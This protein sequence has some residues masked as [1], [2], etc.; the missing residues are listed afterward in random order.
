M[1]G[2]PTSPEAAP[3]Q[4][5]E[6]PAVVAGIGGAA[7]AAAVPEA[8]TPA[9]A[10]EAPAMPEVKEVNVSEQVTVEAPEAVAGAVPGAEA[11]KTPE[12]AT[13]TDTEMV[14]YIL[15]R[16]KADLELPDLKAETPEA[17]KK[18]GEVETSIG[19]FDGVNLELKYDQQQGMEPKPVEEI[20]K[21]K[22][23]IG[24]LRAEALTDEAEKAKVLDEARLADEWAGSY[25][26]RKKR[27]EE[28]QQNSQAATATPEPQAAVPGM[29]GGGEA[30]PGA[31]GAVEPA[32]APVAPEAAT[33][34][35]G[36]P[37]VATP[38]PGE[39]ATQP[40][41]GELT[42]AAEAIEA[43]LREATPPQPQAQPAPADGQLPTEGI[44]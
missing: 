19:I 42:N 36:T 18:R 32:P 41:S 21:R 40:V 39:T 10:P 27:R 23:G 6:N 2:Y 38:V 5:L 7:L 3:A 31:T 16:L 26:N 4:G 29:T 12:T 20:L 17:M 25:L 34:G 11:V 33:P 1:E 37:E 22:A 24:R 9:V 15:G 35:V 28:E 13:V 43:A 30:V 8:A 44:V 14:G